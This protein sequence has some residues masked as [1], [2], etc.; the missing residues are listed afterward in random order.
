[1]TLST[2]VLVKWGTKYKAK[3]VNRLARSI[4]RHCAD[5]PDVI[6]YTDD[7]R[8]IEAC[9]AAPLPDIPGVTTWW[10]KLWLFTIER[11]WL[12][13][14]L[15]VVVTGDLAPLAPFGPLRILKDPWQPRRFNSSVMATDGTM[16]HLWDDIRPADMRRLHGDQDW[17]SERAQGAKVYP[18]G[19]C[20]SYKADV[21][22]QR[23]NAVSAQSALH[24]RPGD[25]CRVV[26]FHGQ[27]KPEAAALMGARW[28]DAEWAA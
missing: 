9:P 26:Y 11:P 14:D 8:G 12:Y 24:S 16:R 15:D 25:D 4:R 19:L 13:L 20:Q 22:G 10:W 27:P 21:I 17:I 2:V 3:D 5:G 18:R 6:C 23:H 7:P 1:M 28:I